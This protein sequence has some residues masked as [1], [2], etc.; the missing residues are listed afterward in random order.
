MGEKPSAAFLPLR[1]LAD[2]ALLVL[3]PS[4][5]TKPAGFGG[6]CLTEGWGR[7]TDALCSVCPPGHGLLPGSRARMST[8]GSSREMLVLC[9]AKLCRAKSLRAGAAQ[10]GSEGA[11]VGV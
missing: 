8:A 7:G 3:P 10:Q 5:S 1:P 6:L 9:C 11:Q 4:P 2:G